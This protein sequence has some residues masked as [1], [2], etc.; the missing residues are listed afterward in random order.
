MYSRNSL[1]ICYLEVS[2]KNKSKVL[3]LNFGNRACAEEFLA[4]RIAQGMPGAQIK[5]FEVP[6]AFLVDLRASAV[7]EAEL[8][9][10]P[11]LRNRPI[12][13]DTTKAPDQFGLR[14]PQ[15]IDLEKNIIQGSGRVSGQ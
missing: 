12:L 5:S 3:W 1:S 7:T 4:Q 8:H 2:I 6:K 14:P 13:A 15:I 10:N 9:A 11:A